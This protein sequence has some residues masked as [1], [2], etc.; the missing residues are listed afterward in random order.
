M[1]MTFAICVT[2]LLLSSSLAY[3]FFAFEDNGMKCD[4]IGGIIVY[5]KRGELKIRCMR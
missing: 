3:A 5:A 1:R 2:L 4:V